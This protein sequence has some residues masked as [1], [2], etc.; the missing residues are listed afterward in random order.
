MRTPLHLWIIASLSLFWNLIGAADYTLTRTRA[1]FYMAG[2]TP[3]QIAYFTGFPLWVQGAWALA[4]WSSV[5]GSLLLLL[6][7]GR[8]AAVFAFSFAAMLVTAFHNYMLDDVRLSD[9][10]GP[11]AIWFSLAIAVVALGE[12]LYARR[13]RQTGV[14][15]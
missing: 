8:A 9:I 6:R 11:E 7:S 4:V 1:E 2:F 13:M 3:E 12:W 10:A 15:G 14:I 5:A